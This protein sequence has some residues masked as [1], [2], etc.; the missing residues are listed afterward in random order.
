MLKAILDLLGRIFVHRNI[1]Q[2]DQE[3]NPRLSG[4]NEE[5]HKPLRYLIGANTYVFHPESI[6]EVSY[7][8]NLCPK[9]ATAIA[10]CNL[11]DEEN[12]GKYRPY[13]HDSDTAQQYNEGQIDPDGPGWERNLTDQFE[14]RKRSGFRYVELDNPDAYRWND[15]RKAMDLASH[16][17]LQVIAKNPGICDQ[18]VA[19]VAYPLVRAIIVEKDCG[20]PEEMERLR[21]QAGKP[22]LPVWFVC[23]AGGRSWGDNIASSASK[24]GNMGVTYSSQG[25]YGNSIDIVKPND[26]SRITQT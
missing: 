11:F 5:L 12:S 8:Y 14:R 4:D 17:G 1:R 2:V 7:N 20:T 21:R 18:P 25:E 24:Y 3:V 9:D 22:T 23:F 10:Y 19:M 26:K 6:T 16:Y 13:L 15:V